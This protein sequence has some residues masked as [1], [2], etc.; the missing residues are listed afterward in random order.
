MTDFK[1]HRTFEHNLQGKYQKVFD[2]L[3][4]P[5]SVLELGCHT[6]YFSRFLAEHGFR[7]VGVEYDG[8]AAQVARNG[9][10]EVI[11]GDVENEAVFDKLAG[12]SFDYI[13]AMDVLEH[14]R[15]PSRVL[16]QLKPLLKES[17]KLLVTGPNVAYWAVR[18]KLLLGHW[19]YEDTGILDRTHLR[20]YTM[21]GWQTLLSNSGFRVATV[22]TAEAMVPFEQFLARLG[23]NE[24]R[25]QKIRHI[26]AK[27]S[28]SLFSIVLLLEANLNRQ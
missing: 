1:Y 11:V 18:A 8:H 17:G 13:L 5:A 23:L 12:Q 2:A 4:S 25:L 24:S 14:L 10:I 21:K 20:F 22:A 19:D 3:S 26:A 6:G 16:V 15:D 28:P 27:V 7:V 9:G